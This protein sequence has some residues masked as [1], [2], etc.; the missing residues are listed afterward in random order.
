MQLACPSCGARETRVSHRLTLLEHLKSLLGIDQMRCRR[1]KAR[2]QTSVWFNS[3]W[4]YARCPRCYRQE[5]TTWDTEQYNTAA[6]TS[7]KLGIGARAQ[8]CA[9]CR[10]N[11]VSFRPRR[12]KF[13]WQHR[14]I[15]PETLPP[16]PQSMAYYAGKEWDQLPTA[17]VSVGDSLPSDHMR[18]ERSSY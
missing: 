6:W 3:A 17:D 12:S 13:A 18:R 7:I 5:L 4:K 8:R 1:C 2:W 15:D 11:F 14:E 10:C 9:A 16:Q